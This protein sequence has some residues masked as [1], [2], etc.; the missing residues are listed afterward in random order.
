MAHNIFMVLMKSMKFMK[1]IKLHQTSFVI[2]MKF[3]KFMI[4]IKIH[5]NLSKFV[6]THDKQTGADC[7]SR[8]NCRT[9][10]IS[11]VREIMATNEIRISQ[12]RTCMTRIE[13]MSDGV[14]IKRWNG[15]IQFEQGGMNNGVS[16]NEINPLSDSFTSSADDY[17]KNNINH[18]FMT[19]K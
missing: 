13:W 5:Q 12:S 14:K 15:L 16:W 19:L 7:P 2:F 17:C 11:F 1:F 8:W 6:N 18:T 10:R 4:F 3:V 9:M